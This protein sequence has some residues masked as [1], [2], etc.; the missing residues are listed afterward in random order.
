MA[1]PIANADPFVHLRE[2]TLLEI[3]IIK[4]ILLERT[5]RV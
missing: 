3:R 4:A 5:P 1:F 2:I